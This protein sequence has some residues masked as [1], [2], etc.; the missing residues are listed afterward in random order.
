MASTLARC[1]GWAHS[2]GVIAARSSM[3]FCM[4][5][6]GCFRS[7]GDTWPAWTVAWPQ[8]LMISLYDVR[9]AW[10]ATSP[11]GSAAAAGADV[12]AAV[13]GATV[14]GVPQAVRRR[15]NRTKYRLMIRSPLVI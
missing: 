9:Y 3:I 6:I 1:A 13:G 14:A 15:T 12:G 7:A 2:G 11:Q 5:S 4:S 8:R 10:S